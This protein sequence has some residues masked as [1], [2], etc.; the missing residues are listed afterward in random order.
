MNRRQKWIL[1]LGFL[2][3]AGTCLFPPWRGKRLDMGKVLFGLPKWSLFW[4]PPEDLKPLS[5][6]GKIKMLT[7]IWIPG[8]IV[9]WGLCF[10][11]FGALFFLFKSEG[12]P[13]KKEN[14]P[15][16]G[17]SKTFFTGSQ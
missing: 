5:F 4:R 8:L 13:P 2:T 16:P 11:F 14:T 7:Q 12:G 1:V 6:I 9:E 15:S 10:S 17:I 3:L